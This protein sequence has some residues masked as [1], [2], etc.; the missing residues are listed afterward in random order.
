MRVSSFVVMRGLD[1]R[2]QDGGHA[3]DARV[4]AYGRP[5]HDENKNWRT[6]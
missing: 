2:I 3:L 6:A 4:T 1:P 5:G